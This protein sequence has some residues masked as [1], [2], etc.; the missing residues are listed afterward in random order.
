MKYLFIF[1]LSFAIISPVYAARKVP[2]SVPDVQPLQPIP[3][4]VSPNIDKNIQFHDPSHEGQFDSS[5]NV[6]T[7]QGPD[8]AKPLNPQNEPA[9]QPGQAAAAKGRGWIWPIVIILLIVGGAAFAI[10][11]WGK[12]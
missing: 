12:Q 10:N 6:V 11:K 1:L 8:Q 2:G 5:G 9:V 4:G 3:A 7:G